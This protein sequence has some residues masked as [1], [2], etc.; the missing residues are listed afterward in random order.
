MTD[1]EKSL[2]LQEY[3]LCLTSARAVETPIWQVGAVIGFTSIGSIALLSTVIK[4]TSLEVLLIIGEVV[5]ALSYVWFKMACR[6]WSIQHTE[7]LRATHIEKLT[8]AYSRQ[9]YISRRDAKREFPKHL[10]R[11]EV[12]QLPDELLRQVDSVGA[13]AIYGTRYYSK[14][15]IALNAASWFL[16]IGYVAFS[17]NSSETLPLPFWLFPVLLLAG[18]IAIWLVDLCIRKAW[19]CHTLCS[20]K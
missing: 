11:A 19:S 12:I 18:L 3:A 17:K 16:Y 9:R 7:F 5:L 13:Y 10:E 14:W 20:G 6:L 8:G 2:M 15:L 4:V 1:E